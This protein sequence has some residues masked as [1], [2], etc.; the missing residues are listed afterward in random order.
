MNKGIFITGTDTAVGKTVITGLLGRFFVEHGINVITQ[1]WVET[2]CGEFSEDMDTHLRLMGIKRQKIEKYLK[3]AV[4]YTFKPASSPHLAARMENRKIDPIVITKAF[5][6]LACKFERVI[7]EGSGG[8]LVPINEG[9]L[10]IDIAK[11]LHLPVLIVAENKLGAINHTLLTIE[12]LK[13]RNLRIIGVIFNRIVE[14]QDDTIL[15]DNLEI[16]EKLS[17]IKVLGEVRYSE[18][19]ETLYE[20]FKFIGKNV[21]RLVNNT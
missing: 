12:S 3:D 13:K 18:N 8:A 19:K 1:K 17:G 11:K 9:E 16:I 14:Q 7:V 5:Q 20:R 2:G 4:P 21:F 15:K 6:N 10:L